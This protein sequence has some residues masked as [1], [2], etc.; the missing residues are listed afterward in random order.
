MMRRILITAAA[1]ALTSGLATAANAEESPSDVPPEVIT[2]DQIGT[3]DVSTTT[4]EG[5]SMSSSALAAEDALMR[6]PYVNTLN[7]VVGPTRC[8]N[9]HKEWYALSNNEN[10]HV[11][12]WWNGTSY[13]DGP[14]GTMKVRVEK[15]GKLGVE[16]SGT[17][18]ASTS[19]IFAK[20]KVSY[21]I[22][23][24]AEVGITVGHEY[25]H[26]IPAKKYGHLQYGSWGYKLK[27]TKY[28]TS[29]DRCGKVKLGSGTAKL[30][31][32]ETGWRYWATS[33]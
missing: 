19:A 25:S 26:E 31:T 9:P 8:D 15:S 14:G 12:S 29:N 10:Y 33:S 11:P 16:V 6:L 17:T 5:D 28:R 24:V 7:D 4:V 23:V 21:S 18:E 27:W 22:K 1:L 3:R 2:D 13:K 30:P 32:K 20:A